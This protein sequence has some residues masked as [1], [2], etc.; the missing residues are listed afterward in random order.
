MSY[1][2][3]VDSPRFYVEYDSSSPSGETRYHKYHR[4]DCTY[5][6][7]LVRGKY[8]FNHTKFVVPAVHAG[9]CTRYRRYSF[10]KPSGHSMRQWALFDMCNGDEGK[11]FYVWLFQT[12][13]EATQHCKMQNADPN[14]AQLSQP[15]AVYW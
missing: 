7:E 14:N 12:F 9:R 11:G 3:P 5:N 6:P 4:S 1:W 13:D 15:Y 2:I 8:E 10:H